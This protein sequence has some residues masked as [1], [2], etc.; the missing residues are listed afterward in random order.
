MPL[1]VRLT[2]LVCMVFIRSQALAQQELL[3]EWQA[4]SNYKLWSPTS[5]ENKKLV[6]DNKLQVIVLLSTEC[7][8][9]ISYTRTLE[10]L[11]KRFS[12]KVNFYGIFPG[13]TYT[14]EKINE[15]V[16]SYK[17]SIPIYIDEKM[18]MTRALKGRVTPEVFLFDSSGNCVYRGAIDD[19]LVELGKKKTK[20][21]Q[22]FLLNAIEQA[23][24][25]EA[26]LITYTK[27]QGC[28]LNDF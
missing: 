17:L 2:L 8:M 13:N 6:T 26:V 11:N 23:L 15:F 19:W 16:S 14:D 7:P 1:Q 24:N 20:P 25:N 18:K 3:P 9:C 4:V 27:A 12:S 21:D 22:H 28:L 5:K 10:E